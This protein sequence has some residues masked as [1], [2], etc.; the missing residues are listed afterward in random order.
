MVWG[1]EVT[2]ETDVIKITKS[3]I[4]FENNGLRT[5]E[6]TQSARNDNLNKAE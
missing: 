4:M 5:K 1:Y 2:M 3:T 6:D